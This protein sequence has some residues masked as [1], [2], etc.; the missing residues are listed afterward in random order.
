MGGELSRHVDIDK[1]KR[2]CIN[3]QRINMHDFT[4]RTQHSV[5]EK[6]RAFWSNYDGIKNKTV[7]NKR[8]NS[9]ENN[10]NH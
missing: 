9:K 6:I 7:K 4:Q 5:R 10:C 2:M 3:T 8:K 1:L